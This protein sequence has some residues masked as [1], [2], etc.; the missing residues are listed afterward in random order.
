MHS[1]FF[2][3]YSLKELDLSNFKTTNANKMGR[4]FSE[5]SSLEELNLSSFDTQNTDDMCYKFL[6]CPPLLTLKIKEL[7][8][9][10][11]KKAFY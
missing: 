7:Y 4:M 1:M 5:C 6:D 10:I 3:C 9:N 8:H 2:I 11:A